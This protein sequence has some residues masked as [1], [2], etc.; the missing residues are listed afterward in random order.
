MITC[1]ERVESVFSLFLSLP[2]DQKH[3]KKADENI[4]TAAISFAGSKY[5]QQKQQQQQDQASFTADKNTKYSRGRILQDERKRAGAK[6]KKR[7][8]KDPLQTT[9]T[10]NNVIATIKLRQSVDCFD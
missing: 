9:Q 6:G 1:Y 5:H 3:N 7:S 2:I 10:S 8:Y 4:I